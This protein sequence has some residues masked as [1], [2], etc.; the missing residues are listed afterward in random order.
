MDQGFT[1]HDA[2]ASV[3]QDLIMR[4]LTLITTGAVFPLRPS[5][6][7]PAMMARTAEVDKALS[8]RQWGGPFDALASGFGRDAMVWY[9]AWLALGR[10]SLVGTTVKEPQP[11]PRAL[12]ADAQLIQVAKPQVYVPTPVGGGCVLGVSGVEA[13]DTVTV[14]RG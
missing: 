11:L 14:E 3:K 13:A 5:C 4:R 12:G 6:V 1:L 9:R 7:M 2:Y 10:P 8:L